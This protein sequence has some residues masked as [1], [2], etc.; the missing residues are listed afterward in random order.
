[1]SLGKSLKQRQK[2]KRKESKSEKESLIVWTGRNLVTCTEACSSLTAVRLLSIQYLYLNHWL[3][4]REEV[5]VEMNQ[6]GSSDMISKNKNQTNILYFGFNLWHHS[7]WMK[8]IWWKQKNE[9]PQCG[10]VDWSV[11]CSEEQVHVYQQGCSNELQVFSPS[12]IVNH[13]IRLWK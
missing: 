12:L 13:F 9:S 10:S 6:F 8:D 2:R 7:R 1:M 3:M 4:I 11:P 5:M